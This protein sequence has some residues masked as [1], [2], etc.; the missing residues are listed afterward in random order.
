MFS[1]GYLIQGLVG[2]QPSTLKSRSLSTS[3]VW[4]QRPLNLTNLPRNLISNPFDTVK[5]RLQVRLNMLMID[6]SFRPKDFYMGSTQALLTVSK[7][8]STGDFDSLSALVHEGT[9]SEVK[10]SYS[11]LSMEQ[12]KLIAVRQE[13]IQGQAPYLFERADDANQQ[14][15]YVKI[16]ILTFVVP[17]FNDTLQKV[18]SPRNTPSEFS[19]A[20]NVFKHNLMICDYR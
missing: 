11:S 1:R 16:G 8:I 3:P 4:H 6:T 14:A 15:I 13:D 12:R 7:Y 9:L 19:E 2:R 10:Q 20:A 5:K 18:F 17:G